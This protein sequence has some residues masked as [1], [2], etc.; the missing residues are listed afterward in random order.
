MARVHASE[1]FT[2]NFLHHSGELLGHPAADYRHSD[3]SGQKSGEGRLCRLIV[4]DLALL[5]GS[6]LGRELAPHS[7]VSDS[8]PRC[9]HGVDYT[10]ALYN[11][12]TNAHHDGVQDTRISRF[13]ELAVCRDLAEAHQHISTRNAHLIEG[14]PTVVFGVVANLRTKVAS[15]DPRAKLPRIHISRLR[16][17]WLHAIVLP[18]DD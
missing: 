1:D 2:P 7:A 6:L 12:H 5:P 3:T 10:L 17:E 4:N 11:K 18:I 14:G 16:H 8:I 9:R 13:R 15:L